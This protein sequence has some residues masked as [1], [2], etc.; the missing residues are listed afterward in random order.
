MQ[1]T[2][3]RLTPREHDVARLLAYGYTNSSIGERLGISIRTVEMHR[4]HAMRKLGVRS[5]SEVVRWA[6]DE[7]LLR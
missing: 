1:T 4:A 2:S 3:L 6:L 7:K 5:R